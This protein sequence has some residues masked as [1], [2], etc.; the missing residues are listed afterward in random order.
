MNI[1]Y[2]DGPED[3]LSLGDPGVVWKAFGELGRLLE[4]HPDFDELQSVPGFG[5]QTVTPWWLNRVREQAAQCL[6]RFKPLLSERTQTVLVTL[7]AAP[8]LPES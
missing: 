6:G 3:A 4:D 1:W 7:A 5:E 8:A 2:G